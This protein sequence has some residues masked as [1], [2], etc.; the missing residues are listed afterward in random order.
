MAD[1]QWAS[2]R[3]LLRRRP[4][5]TAGTLALAVPVAVLTV[6]YVNQANHWFMTD[7]QVYRWGGLLAR[8]SGPLYTAEFGGAL[9]FT[10]PPV[11]AAVFELLSVL[12]ML[13]VKEIVITGS[14]LALFAS[15][16]FAWGGAGVR[17]SWARAAAALA[18]TDIALCTDPVQQTIDLGQVNLIL[19]AVVLA[20]LLAPGDRWW[21]GA[22]VGLA[23]GLKLTPGIF[24]AYLLVTRR[25]RA[26]GAATVAFALTVAA[27]FV[28]L[29]GPSRQYWLGG[30]FLDSGRPGPVIYASNQSLS[31]AIARLAGGGR[32]AL[33]YWLAAALLVAAGGLLAARWAHR[34]GCE[35]AAVSV[36]AVTGLLVSPVSWDHHWVWIVP[37]LVTVAHAAWRHRSWA[38]WVGL[39]GLIL[40]FLAYPAVGQPG[41]PAAMKGLIWS[42]PAGGQRE[43][44]WHGWQ[45]VRGNLYTLAGLGMLCAAVVAVFHGRS[46]RRVGREPPVPAARVLRND[47]AGGGSDHLRGTER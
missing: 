14:V 18:V 17:G 12:P 16:W 45:L 23:T 21:R 5:L 20:D 40:V 9:S 47:G 29:P 13:A 15:A 19:M 44:G 25:F 39:A 27:G 1:G 30:L 10:Y 36:C 37:V 34:R 2:D 7:L 42:V 32:P 38:A 3:T 4:G 26:A 46:R 11:A 6:V 8:R 28:V 24:I 33:P 41:D 31:G 35:L 22:G 43:Y